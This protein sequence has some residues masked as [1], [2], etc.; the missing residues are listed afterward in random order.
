MLNVASALSRR[1]TCPKLQV[2]AVLVDDAGRI[3]GTGY[4]G[5]PRGMPHCTETPCVGA[6]TPSGSDLCEAVHA[7]QNALMQCRDIERIYA[8]YC[9]H[10][11]CL[12]CTKMLLNTPCLVIRFLDDSKIEEAA[13]ALWLKAGRVWTPGSA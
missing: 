7:E 4:N 10:A 1:A 11:P 2:G 12:R 8:L 13:R 9:T 5:V 6:E 3:L